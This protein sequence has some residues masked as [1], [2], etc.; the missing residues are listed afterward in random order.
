MCDVVFQLL[1]YLILTAKPLLVTTALEINRPQP[2]LDLIPPPPI[3][4]VE[5]MVFK[6]DYTVCGKRVTPGGLDRT[7]QQLANMDKGQ[8]V[9]VK[10]APDSS[11]EKLIEVLNLCSGAKMPKIS[12]LSM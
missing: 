10:C 4:M 7:L 2:P 5:I 9:I 6:D 11:H 12:V 1:I 8:T 3:P